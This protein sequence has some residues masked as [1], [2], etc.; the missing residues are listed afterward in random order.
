MIRSWKLCASVAAA[1][2]YARPLKF[3]KLI[4]ANAMVGVRKLLVVLFVPDVALFLPR[5]PH[6]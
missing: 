6:P 1:V 2:I 3:P 5:L 4:G